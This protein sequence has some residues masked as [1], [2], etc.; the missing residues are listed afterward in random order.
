MEFWTTLLSVAEANEQAT[1]AL[2]ANCIHVAGPF[3]I[4]E[5]ETEYLR[6]EGVRFEEVAEGAVEAL[7]DL[8]QGELIAVCKKSFGVDIVPW[9]TDKCAEC[10]AP[11]NNG[12]PVHPPL[13]STCTNI[14]YPPCG[15]TDLYASLADEDYTEQN[16]EALPL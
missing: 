3:W 7:G 8:S 9:P 2:Q 14:W 5:G 13:C 15:D 1:K 4:M 10:G 12:T 11:E 16:A 6:D